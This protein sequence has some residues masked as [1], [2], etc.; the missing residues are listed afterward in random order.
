MS[1]RPPH[2]HS[3]QKQ[4]GRGA[5]TAGRAGAVIIGAGF[6]PTANPVI[7]LTQLLKAECEEA[8]RECLAHDSWEEQIG[9]MYNIFVII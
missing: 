8:L 5:D 9:L 3:I 4:E 1:Q 6:V 7:K 2:P